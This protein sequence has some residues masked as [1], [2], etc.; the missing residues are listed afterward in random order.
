[1]S[2][3]DVGIRTE[4]PFTLPVGYLDNDGVVHQSGQMR[5]ATAADEIL[6][7][8]DPR[9]QANPAY[10][11]IIVLSRVVSRLGSVEAVNPNVIENLYA[12]DLTFLQELYNTANGTGTVM[13]S[14]VCPNCGHQHETPLDGSGKSTSTPATALSGR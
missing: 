9:V 13:V 3:D 4:F 2:R 11:S 10:L 12:A 7:L 5:L 14:V 6:P 1:V 8:R